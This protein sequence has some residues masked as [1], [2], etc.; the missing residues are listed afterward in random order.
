[1]GGRSKVSGTLNG[2]LGAAWKLTSCALKYARWEPS[3]APASLTP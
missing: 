3:T 2:T 1:L